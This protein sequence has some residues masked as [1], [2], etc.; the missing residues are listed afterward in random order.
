MTRTLRRTDTEIK[1]AVVEE[2]EWVPNVNS[3]HIGVAVDDGAVTLSGEVDSYPEMFL[4]AKVVSGVRGVTAIAQEITV[5]DSW[6]GANDSDIAREAGE[7]VRR[8]V[9]VPDSVKVSVHDHT[10]TLSGIVPWYHDRAAASRA[11]RHLR[12][13]KAVVNS[14]E[15]RPHVSSTGVKT[16]ITAAMVRSALLEGKDIKVTT[17][18][19]GVVTLEGNVRS[20][21]ERRQAEHVSWSTAG[22][23]NVVNHLRIEH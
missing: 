5:R 2:L 4:A 11:V 12:G 15:I 7:A 21:A 8:A 6:G 13:V 22:V 9:D 3:T 18:D 14:I 1:T 20:W 19:A 17:D 23:A 10:V 16:A